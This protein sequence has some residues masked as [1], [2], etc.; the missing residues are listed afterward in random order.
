MT[1]FGNPQGNAAQLSVD[2]QGRFWALC[3]V[4]ADTE[5]GGGRIVAVQDFQNVTGVR[6]RAVIESRY[7]ALRVGIGTCRG[8]RNFHEHLLASGRQGSQTL[9]D[10][11]GNL[12]GISPQYV[13]V[14]GRSAELGAGG[15][16][17]FRLL[18][19]EK[20]SDRIHTR[21]YLMSG[22]DRTEWSDPW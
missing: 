10:L 13:T 11:L 5:G 4:R 16:G 3:D 19:A 1:I 22:T 21:I 8:A 17:E 12:T 14:L 6:R 9:R 7:N 20:I 18:P 2:P 15:L